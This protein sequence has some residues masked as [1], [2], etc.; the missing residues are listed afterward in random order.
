MENI[1]SRTGWLI[2]IV[3]A[4][5]AAIIVGRQW[6]FVEAAC[7]RL[8]DALLFSAT[9]LIVILVGLYAITTRNDSFLSQMRTIG[10]VFAV[11]L[12]APAL[13]GPLLSQS[14]DVRAEFCATCD[15]L[16]ARGEELRQA[17]E[18]D[19]NSQEK[20]GKLKSAEFFVRQCIAQNDIQARTSAGRVL[21]RIL[22]DKAAVLLEQQNCP[23]A[24]KA[25]EEALGLAAQYGP[26]ELELAIKTKQQNYTLICATP[27]PTAV[28]TL[29]FTPTRTLSP[30]PTSTPTWT[31]LPPT[32]TKTPTW[33]P[34]PPTATATKTP[35][36]T[37]TPTLVPDP[38]TCTPPDYDHIE[39]VPILPNGKDQKGPFGEDQG[40]FFDSGVIPISHRFKGNKNEYVCIANLPGGR[41]DLWVDDYLLLKVIHADGSVSNWGHDFYDRATKGIGTYRASDITDMFTPGKNSLQIVLTDIWPRYYHSG[42]IFVTIWERR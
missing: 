29:T 24:N 17:A 12:I 32:A 18:K 37:P 41:G 26:P 36:A 23:E 2:F 15:Q 3:L 6:L 40:V 22:F 21:A 9:G 31:P 34:L 11:G 16:V 14:S 4:G 35:T 8:Q 33:T 5:L 13:F 10:V 42:P 39:V 27:V 38:P 28:P 7:S 20:L 19:S 1:R 25:L 30:T